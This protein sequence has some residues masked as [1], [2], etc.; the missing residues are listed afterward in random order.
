MPR[1]SFSTES[2]QSRH[3]D[4][5]KAAVPSNLAEAPLQCE[6]L[7]RPLF[8]M[9]TPPRTSG[10]LVAAHSTL[11]ALLLEVRRRNRSP[12]VVIGKFSCKGEVAR[13]PD[14]RACASARRA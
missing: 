8:S 2:A 1:A 11:T 10:F 3:P 13:R 9:L 14:A 12:N 4:C 7:S 5:A 6:A